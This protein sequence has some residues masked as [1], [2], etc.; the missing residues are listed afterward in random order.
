MKLV[1]TFKVGRLTCHT[2]E[3]GLQRLDGGAMFG[4]V[5][6]ALWARK[7]P[8]DER[9]RIPLAM[10]CLLIEHD[11]GPVL[12]DTGAGNKES[13]KFKGIYGLDNAGAEG[14]TQLED[15]LHTLGL[16][17]DDVRF[18]LNTHL[19]FDHAGG[20]TFVPE[21][22]MDD[23]AVQLAF[24][25]ASYVVQQGEL[26]FANDT[27]ERT[28]PSYLA[29]NF[30]PVQNAER[31]RLA[32]GEVEILPGIRLVPTPGHVPF[33]QS[34]VVSD[35]GDVAFF[36][37]DMV[38]TTA[39]LPLNWIMGYDLEPLVTMETKRRWLAKAEAESWLLVFEHDPQYGLG[40]VVREGKSYG[41]QAVGG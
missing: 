14:P 2:L 21:E 22:G 1:H 11:A 23:G 20:N 17:P 24:P 15:A 26:A 41:F 9:N 38:P 16:A 18:V 10:R 39:H 40:R 3:S 32:D 35:G 29:R 30:Q 12:V 7:L 33:H 13:D 25:K 31:W 34:V 37:G 36:L 6:K 8:A 28:A 27:N 5:P 4:V 19:H